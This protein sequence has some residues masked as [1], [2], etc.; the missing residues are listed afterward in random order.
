M[1][2]APRLGAAA[3]L[4][5]AAALL[6]LATPAAADTN[7]TT[8]DPIMLCNV[9]LLSPGARVDGAC[10]A[11]QIADQRI[12]QRDSLTYDVIDALPLTLL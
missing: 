8:Q 3:A 11:V 6:A 5:A 4:S 12:V 10:E 1:S 2:R 9:V 7:Q